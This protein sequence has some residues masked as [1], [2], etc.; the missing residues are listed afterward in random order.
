[1]SRSEKIAN[2]F[3]PTSAKGNRQFL[4][5]LDATIASFSDSYVSVE[6]GITAIWGDNCI[7]Q[8]NKIEI[9]ENIL[10]RL[11]LLV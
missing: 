9:E 6:S 10:K 11:S 2:V 7:K 5:N 3:D 1:M 8:D 4:R